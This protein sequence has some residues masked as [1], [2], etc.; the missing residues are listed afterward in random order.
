MFRLMRD[1]CA[2]PPTDDILDHI[3]ALPEPQQRDA[4]AKIQAIE[5]EAMA[6]QI[7][8]AGLVQLMEFLDR[9]GVRKGI[10]TRNFEYVFL[11]PRHTY[12]LRLSRRLSV[13][14]GV[15]IR[16]PPAHPSST[17]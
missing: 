4:F 15:L 3:H 9:W 2:I 7:P 12:P 11:F 8:Q 14:I 17:S 16:C 10:C 13:G 1:A 5:R 6:Q